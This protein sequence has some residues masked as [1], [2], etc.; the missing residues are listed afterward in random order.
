MAYVAGTPQLAFAIIVVI[1]FNGLF[2]F[3][4]E[5]RAKRAAE[6][7]RDLLPRRATVIRAGQMLEVDA[8]ELV[9]NTFRTCIDT[10]RDSSPIWL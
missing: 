5:Y 7:S 10:H 2:A 6:R 1:V 4:Q 9:V 3:A 8:S